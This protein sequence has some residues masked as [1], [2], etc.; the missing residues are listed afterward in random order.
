MR[1][2][3][4]KPFSNSRKQ[5]RS[6]VYKGPF[7]QVTDDAG[8]IYQCGEP[9]EISDAEWS[10]LQIAAPDAFIERILEPSTAAAIR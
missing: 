7:S 9:V 2:S 3:A 5:Q 10:V 4:V 1:L 6:V 8:N